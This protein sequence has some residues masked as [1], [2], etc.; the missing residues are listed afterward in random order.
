MR[1]RMRVSRN[2]TLRGLEYVF[3]FLGLAA[4]DYYIWVNASAAVYQ[5]YEEWRFER[6]IQG[7]TASIADYIFDEHG[8]RRLVGLGNA[9]ERESAARPPAP[10]R[11]LAPHRRRH[12]RDEMLGRIEIPRLQ[13]A[14]IVREGVDQGTLS[15]AVGH[16]PSTAWPG[17]NGNVALA[18]HRDTF[19]RALR[20]IRKNDKIIVSTLDG[21]YEYLVQ[22]TKIVYPSDV[23]VLKASESRELTL[24]TCYP[25]YYIGS[26]PKRFI[27]QARQVGAAPQQQM[28]SSVSRTG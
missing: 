20:N 25:F 19:F 23:S 12:A 27:V 14:A 11:T 10:P 1:I 17:E 3:L 7:E 2:S 15:R 4:I 22:S 16:I 9:P 18:G 26:A 21:N 28:E 8:L 6:T 13:V 24:V 5:S